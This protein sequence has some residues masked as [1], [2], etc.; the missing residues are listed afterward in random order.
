MPRPRTIS[1]LLAF[2]TMLVYLP[3]TRNGFVDFDDD[4][5]VTQNPIVQKGLTWSGVKWALTTRH[6]SN[7]H[8]V[9]WLS[10]MAD[11]QA[12]HLNP[13]GHHWD[14]ILLHAV[15][16]ALL[17]V[18]LWQLTDALWP[19]AFI[20]ALFAWHPL[21]VES[22]AWVSERKD[23]LSTC[24]ALLT[25]LAYVNAVAR[26][27]HPATGNESGPCPHASRFILHASPCYWL[28]LLFFAL[29]LMSKPMLVTLPFVML[30]LDYWP[31]QRF[32]V[33]TAEAPTALLPR[34]LVEKIPFFLLAAAASVITFLVQKNDA[35]AALAK[36]PLPFRFANAIVACAGYLG[37]TIC[38]IHLAVFYPLPIHIA[39]LSVLAAAVALA[40]ATALVIFARKQC[41]YLLV[42]WLWF[43]GTLVPV[44]GLVQVGDQAMADRYTY[45]PLIGIFIALAFLARDAVRRW[46]F[47]KTPSVAATLLILPACIIVT[48]RQLTFW[49]DSESL[50]THALAVTPENAL[51]HLNLGA[52]L[53]AQNKPDAALA[54]YQKV[55]QLDPHRHEVYNNLG[56]LLLTRGQPQAA[57]LYC[58]QAVQLDPQSPLSHNSLG[59]VLLELGRLDEASSEF[60]EAIRLDG[61]YASPR[62][63]MGRLLLKQGHDA[64]AVQNLHAALQIEPDNLQMVIYLARVLAA[65]ENAQIRDGNQ[66]L[67]LALRAGRLAGT[68]QPVVLD[69]LAMAYAELGRFDQAIQTEQQAA[70]LAEATGPGNDDSTMRQRLERYRN[71][72]PWRQSFKSD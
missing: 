1:L 43:L 14:N 63:L 34:L 32:T 9:T 47:L 49:R 52:A 51:S 39:W 33:I 69:T 72:L 56:K 3:A 20:A 71:H 42:G 6:A 24:F 36:V 15:N 68:N 21:H 12:F 38:P 45:F 22:V 55:L 25:L 13:A 8:P 5:Y 18:L 60:S 59:I 48:E 67:T 54:E 64:E 29:G 58:R 50:F 16:A 27:R 35:V 7:W 37:K 61:D 10:H 28:A 57:L 66:A 40:L 17:F 62:F 30:L 26:G 31:L 11:C 23:V 46:P 44:I 65:D 41:P 19:G 2:V 53:E 70:T 4:D